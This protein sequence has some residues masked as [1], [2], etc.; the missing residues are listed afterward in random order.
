MSSAAFCS[1]ELDPLTQS[2]H[3]LG[4]RRHPHM[5]RASLELLFGKHEVQFMGV[6]EEQRNDAT[7]VPVA[8]M[9]VL[10]RPIAL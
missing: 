9:N 10:V 6:L 3:R 4:L 1:M 5:A 8:L 2:G 7:H